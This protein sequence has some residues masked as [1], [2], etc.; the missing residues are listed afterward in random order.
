MTWQEHLKKCAR[1]WQ[2]MKKARKNAE[3]DARKKT[4]EEATKKAEEE[5]AKKAEEEYNSE[6]KQAERQLKLEELKSEV[7]EAEN[8]LNEARKKFD[9][10]LE[11]CAK[12]HKKLLQLDQCEARAHYKA[13]ILPLIEMKGKLKKYELEKSSEHSAKYNEYS[14][15]LSKV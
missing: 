6:E 2:E 12:E 14:R 9:V 10:C 3:E 1:E 5:A 8:A 13:T 4:E 15:L 7:C 11:E